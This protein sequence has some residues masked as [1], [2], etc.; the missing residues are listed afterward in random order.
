[1]QPHIRKAVI[2]V[3]GYGTRFLP[4]T[5]TIPKELVPVLDKPII[6]YVVEEALASGIEEIL[7]VTNETKRSLQ[8]YLSDIP[9]LKPHLRFMTQIGPYGSATPILNAKSFIGDEPFAVLLGDELFVA[10]VPRIRQ[11]INA[12]EKTGDPMLGVIRTDDAGTKRYGI[13][14]P[15]SPKTDQT[16][17]VFDFSEKPGPERAPSRLASI[18][19]YILTPDIFDAI[20]RIGP[21]ANGEFQLTDAFRLLMADRPFYGC[22]LDGDYFDVGTKLGW[23]EANIAMALRSEELGKEAVEFMKGMLSK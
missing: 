11:L 22:Q 5:K 6:Q 2:P 23:L 16:F 10:E 17:R 14:D 1:M 7:L 3:A 9:E 21:A 18:G 13:V 20:N 4:L 12:F 19:A 8:E 15:R